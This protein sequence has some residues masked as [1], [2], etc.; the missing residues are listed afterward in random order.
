MVSDGQQEQ[1]Q[2]MEDRGV[3][4]D[5]LH[6]AVA[7]ATPKWVRVKIADDGGTR[8][9]PDC[10]VVFVYAEITN[11]YYTAAFD[12][13]KAVERLMQI[14]PDEPIEVLLRGHPNHDLL[15]KGSLREQQF[16]LYVTTHPY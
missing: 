5:A 4:F 11:D 9:C 13:G 7:V 10:V 15:L 14:P 1:D 8:D 16:C 6:E 3:L 12:I 2:R